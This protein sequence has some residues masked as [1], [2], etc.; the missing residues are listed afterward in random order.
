MQFLAQLIEVALNELFEKCVLELPPEELDSFQ[1]ECE[2]ENYGINEPLY[3]VTL[4]GWQI[5]VWWM[6]Y[7]DG[8]RKLEAYHA[9]SIAI[10][11]CQGC[12]AIYP[13]S[14]L[15]DFHGRKLCDHC[16]FQCPVVTIKQG[17]LQ[18]LPVSMPTS[19]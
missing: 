19:D 14:E 6:Y 16:R 11:E 3:L 18:A 13:E 1:A 5:F 12:T 17:N 8:T 7:G 2:I 4:C 9:Q 15:R 10:G